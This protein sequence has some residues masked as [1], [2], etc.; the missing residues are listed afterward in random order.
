M[1]HLTTMKL[2]QCF[3]I[4]NVTPSMAWKDVKKSYH[5]LAKRYHPDLNPRSIVSENK[6]K[7][8]NGAFKML[9]THYKDPERNR[10]Q[11]VFSIF[12]SSAKSSSLHSGGALLSTEVIE[13]SKPKLSEDRKSVV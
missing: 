2:S 1:N 11:S 7:E 9:E 3:S 4:L 10:R 5:Q 6:F 8:L 12:R 13:G